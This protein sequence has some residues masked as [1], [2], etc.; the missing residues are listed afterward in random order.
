VLDGTTLPKTAASEATPCPTST[1]FD[2]GRRTERQA[3]PTG[4]QRKPTCVSDGIPTTSLTDS[5]LSPVESV[6]APW[7]RQSSGEPFLLRP[8]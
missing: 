7:D 8:A 3:A 1:S 5:A 2:T 6:T 4:G